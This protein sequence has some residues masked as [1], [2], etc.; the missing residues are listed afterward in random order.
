MYIRPCTVL[1]KAT[2]PNFIH[3]EAMLQGTT[4]K[5]SISDNIN[6]SEAWIDK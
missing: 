6:G 1:R 4:W 5:K 3:T 2:C